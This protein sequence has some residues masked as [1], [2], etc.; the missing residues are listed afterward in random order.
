MAAKREG[1]DLELEVGRCKLLQLEGITSKAL[2]NST[3]N[4]TQYPVI[5]HN[6]KEYENE[7][8]CVCN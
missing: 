8:M 5:K 6:G 7:C 1:M 3:G 2:I 4:Y